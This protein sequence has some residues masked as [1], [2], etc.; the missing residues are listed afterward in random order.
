[1]IW[2][3]LFPDLTFVIAFAAGPTLH[4]YSYLLARMEIDNSVGAVT[5]HGTI[6]F[7]CLIIQS[8]FVSPYPALDA[9]MGEALR[10]TSSL[11]GQIVEVVVFCS[12]RFVQGY[13]ISLILKL[14]GM[15]RTLGAAEFAG[16]D[17]V[18]VHT[19]GS[20]RHSS[21]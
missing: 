8:I 4:P 3:S 13:L 17:P 19:Q 6:D 7:V 21:L 10:P 12:L 16:L 11:T 5:E 14:V 2:I 9:F 1:M 18:E 20:R 15:L